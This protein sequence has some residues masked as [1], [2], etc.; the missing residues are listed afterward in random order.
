MSSFFKISSKPLWGLSGARSKWSY[1]ETICTLQRK[2]YQVMQENWCWLQCIQRK[3][4]FEIFLHKCEA[5]RFT[6]GWWHK[7][8]WGEW[9][10][11]YIHTT[12]YVFWQM[13]DFFWYFREQI[14]LHWFWPGIGAITM[15]ASMGHSRHR[16]MA[17]IQSK[18]V[19][20]AV[21]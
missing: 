8:L 4:G 6:A 11:G 2:R 5:K 9:S 7:V 21:M 1:W 12:F 19:V 10:I 18:T 13:T 20:K 15:I 14:L 3:S 17:H 16:G